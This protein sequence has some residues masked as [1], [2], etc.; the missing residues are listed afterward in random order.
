MV[1]SLGLAC[2]DQA[3]AKPPR[4]VP[5]GQESRVSA[6][7][8]DEAA[9]FQYEGPKTADEASRRSTN[10]CC[11]GSPPASRSHRAGTSN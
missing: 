5:L 9:L 10:R 6:E 2:D 7:G 11:A 4:L 3:T 1:I 8:C